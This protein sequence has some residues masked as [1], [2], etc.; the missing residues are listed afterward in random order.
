MS[1]V[2]EILFYGTV[3]TPTNR[4]LPT[5]PSSSP[6]NPYGEEGQLPELK[7]HAL[8]L[9]SG[10]LN[11]AALQNRPSDFQ[12]HLDTHPQFISNSN[13]TGDTT[14]TSPKRARDVFDEAAHRRK[15]A[16]AKGG[17]GVAAAAARAQDIQKPYIHRRSL[18]IETKGIPL[19]GSRP[20]SA[21]G[22]QPSPRILSRSPSISSD[23]RPLSRKGTADGPSKRSHLSQVATVPIHPE[24]PT[25][26]SRNKEA[27]SRVVMAAMRM[28]GLQQRKKPKSRRSSLAPGPEQD[29]PTEETTVEEASKDEEYKLIYH[30]TYKGAAL[31]LVIC[32]R[33]E[34]QTQETLTVIA[35]ETHGNETFTHP[36][37]PA[38][39][40]R[41]KIAR[42]ILHGS[43][44]ATTSQRYLGRPLGYAR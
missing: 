28:H 26:E 29:Q 3:A 35:E 11:H 12:S 23:T 25:I 31:A 19:P 21:Q 38:R 18:S 41:R 42:H 30:Q 5:P 8:P 9:S 43:A 34:L 27:L 6:E 20:S 7:V 4:I 14:P 1:K 10:L 37:R 39:R 36:A 17:E 40:C 32:A 13:T 22:A 2:T 44:R 24:E 16:R 33:P 15:K